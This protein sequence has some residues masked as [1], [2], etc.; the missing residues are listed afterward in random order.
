L[1]LVAWLNDG[2]L[3]VNLDSVFR[4]S[5]PELVEQN[6]RVDRDP[7]S[8]KKSGRR[9]DE[10]ARDESERVL[11]STVDHSMA[12]IWSVPASNTNVRLVL[13]C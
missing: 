9:V 8:N 13:H 7:G 6:G 4:V 5:F 2:A 12:G 1:L 10:A 3:I 11:N